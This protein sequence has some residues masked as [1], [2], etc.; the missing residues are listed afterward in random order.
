ML[1]KREG[2]WVGGREG[3][4][5]ELWREGMLSR[6]ESSWVGGWKKSRMELGAHSI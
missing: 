5:R 6:R 3:K 2:L 4:I 1:G